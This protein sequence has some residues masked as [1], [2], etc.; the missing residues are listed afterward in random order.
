MSFTISDLKVGMKVEIEY[1][2][3]QYEDN[4]HE[5]GDSKE[6][7]DSED[8]TLI[9]KITTIEKIRNNGDIVFKGIGQ[10]LSIDYIKSIL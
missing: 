2:F 6:N 1:E 7:Y 4:I 8:F 3:N 10:V 9:N 5:I